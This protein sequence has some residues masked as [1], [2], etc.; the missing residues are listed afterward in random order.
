MINVVAELNERTTFAEA[1]VAA[2]ESRADAAEARSDEAM[3][4]ATAMQREGKHGLQRAMPRQP[5][6][7]AALSDDEFVALK[8]ELAA[9]NAKVIELTRVEQQLRESMIAVVNEFNQRT[10][11]AEARV[12]T[13]EARADAAE[14]RSDDAMRLATSVQ[15]DEKKRRLSQ[16]VIPAGAGGLIASAAAATAG[17]GDAAAL[18]EAR[19]EISSLRE[20]LAAS[21]AKVSTLVSVEKELRKSMINVVAEF[22]ERTTFAEAR[23]AAAESR[24]DAAE[25]RSD[26][27]MRLATRMQQDERRRRASQGHALVHMTMPS[28]PTPAAAPVAAPPP[29]EEATTEAPAEGSYHL[30]GTRFRGAT[31]EYRALEEWVAPS[32]VVAINAELDETPAGA[33]AS[34]AASAVAAGFVRQASTESVRRL[35]SAG[36]DSKLLPS[37]VEV[38][39]EE[40]VE[41]PTTPTAAT[42]HVTFAAIKLEQPDD[43]P[44]EPAQPPAEPDYSPVPTPTNREPPMTLDAPPTKPPDEPDAAPMEGAPAEPPEPD[45]SSFSSINE[46]LEWVGVGFGAK[47]GPA[48]DE[49][50]ADDISFLSMMDDEITKEVEGELLKAGADEAQIRK[51]ITAI[52]GDGR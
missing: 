29:K 13:A 34:P 32:S 38:P 22:N 15:R 17:G 43:V 18:E 2:A 25:A 28:S 49:L 31:N 14:L 36:M 39:A 8:E 42:G 12:E 27:A 5:S 9:A 6:M 23:V 1:R 24:A 11:A 48:F 33:L 26:E 20:K 7:G 50:G 21:D 45:A 41:T 47:F 4:L 3:R 19:K 16:G 51:I 44:N 10:L 40:P 52:N 30:G 35:S 37:E 46:W